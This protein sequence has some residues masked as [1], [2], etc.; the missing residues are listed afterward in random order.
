MGKCHIR[1]RVPARGVMTANHFP[2][3]ACV[4]EIYVLEELYGNYHTMC[5]NSPMAFQ[6][7]Q[8]V[9]FC[10]VATSN[11]HCRYRCG[12]VAIGSEEGVCL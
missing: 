5:G 9:F 3:G 12:G 8:V 7:K 1:V 10:R 11:C 6:L 4:T 2:Y